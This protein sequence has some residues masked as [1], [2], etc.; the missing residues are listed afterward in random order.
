MEEARTSDFQPVYHR[1]RH[2]VYLMISSSMPGDEQRPLTTEKELCELFHASRGT[3]RK[4]LRKLCDEGLLISRPH[5]GTFLNPLVLQRTIQKPVLGI[6]VGNGDYTFFDEHIQRT[7]CGVYRCASRNGY[8]VHPIRFA[9]GADY[10]LSAE[11]KSGLSGV[12]W[13]WTPP[14]AER[15]MNMLEEQNIPQVHI[16]PLV[17]KVRGGLVMIDGEDYGY[18]TARRAIAAGYPDTLY[19]EDPLSVFSGERLKG[20]RRAFRE[21]GIPWKKS[22]FLKASIETIW[23]IAEQ[24]IASGNHRAV[25]CSGRQASLIRKFPGL[26]VI[27]PVCGTDALRGKESGIPVQPILPAEE[28]GRIGTEMLIAHSGK[29]AAELREKIVLK[30][31]FLNS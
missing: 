21:A 18:Q 8:I 25:C 30:M 19:L 4:A 5:Y 31:E 14:S 1:I 11:L 13:I 12:L 27:S 10:L 28:S 16:I 9:D 23:K 3:V 17:E 20:I 15:V 22:C 24:R 6:L 2:H 7:L 29:P 26:K